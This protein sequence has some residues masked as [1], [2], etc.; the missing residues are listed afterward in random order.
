MPVVGLEPISKSDIFGICSD[1]L[2][3][4][5]DI[6]GF[7]YP[8]IFLCSPFERIHYATR[9]ATRKKY[10]KFLYSVAWLTKYLYLPTLSQII[11]KSSQIKRF[12]ISFLVS[13]SSDIS[14]ALGHFR[15][16]SENL[17]SNPT[18]MLSKRFIFEIYG[19]AAFSQQNTQL[20]RKSYVTQTHWQVTSKLKNPVFMLLSKN[21]G[22][23]WRVFC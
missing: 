11:P 9:N 12:I 21:I 23:F 18:F 8:F 4:C 20:S 10:N 19:P 13:G 6:F 17:L 7:S 3:F 5:S 1:I 2:G 22:E 14:D 16:F 15:T